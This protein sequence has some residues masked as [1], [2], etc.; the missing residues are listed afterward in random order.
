MVCVATPV[1]GP[2]HTVV[3]WIAVTGPVHGLDV[4]A[5]SHRLRRAAYSSTLDLVRSPALAT[6]RR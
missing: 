2:A 3:A 6:P 4:P 5:V 1:R